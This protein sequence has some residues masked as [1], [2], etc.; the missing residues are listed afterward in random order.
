[1]QDVVLAMLAKEPSHGYELQLRLQM[2]L[3][4]A[5]AALNAGQIYV[6]LGRLERAG[7]VAVVDSAQGARS[8]SDRKV[9][10]L[11]TAGHERART[12]FEA[13]SWPRPS[14]GEFHLKVALAAHTHLADPVKVLSSHRHEVLRQLRQIQQTRLDSPPDSPT[15]LLLEG[16]A[17]RLDAELRWL[18][19]AADYW[20]RAM[21]TGGAGPPPPQAPPQA[22]AQAPNNS[23]QVRTRQAGRDEA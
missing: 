7:L 9:Y 6:T 2:M 23:G 13:V 17:L 22:Q 1:M 18:D 20:R 16:L 15:S 3:G 10:E 5:T 8:S 19:V 4:E 11:T 21:G 12:W 14:L